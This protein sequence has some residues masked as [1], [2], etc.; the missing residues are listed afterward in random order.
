MLTAFVDRGLELRSD[1]IKYHAQGEHGEIDKLT[2]A[3]AASADSEV[4][5]HSTYETQTAVMV[6]K[7]P[8]GD[9][10][11]SQVQTKLVSATNHIHVICL[12]MH[13][14]CIHALH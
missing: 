9:M 5:T 12:D 14:S 8:G 7:V 13:V 11:C 10:F 6:Y 1:E 3:A 4:M 2:G